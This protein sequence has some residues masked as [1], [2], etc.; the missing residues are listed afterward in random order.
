MKKYFLGLLLL[1]IT[2]LNAQVT[3]VLNDSVYLKYSN[4]IN[5]NGKTNYLG[6]DNIYSTDLIVYRDSSKKHINSIT[7]VMN[8]YIKRHIRNMPDSNAIETEVNYFDNQIERKTYNSN[9]DCV[10]IS[11][12]NYSNTQG[13]Y[14]DINNFHPNTT[15]DF[16]NDSTISSIYYPGL[17]I[18]NKYIISYN[19]MLLSY[20]EY[21]LNGN[22]RL[23]L[24]KKNEEYV[25][26]L[27]YESG[28][29][30]NFGTLRQ[31]TS[32]LQKNSLEI[33]NLIFDK[34]KL[35]NYY[36]KQG[37]IERTEHY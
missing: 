32:K 34:I 26:F 15:L 36:D 2:Q 19:D 1:A 27:F 30:Q 6:D 14:I 28:M 5:Y 11:F 9:G 35:W 22:I 31:N 16:S 21:H 33:N 4:L 12:A 13:F 17:N 20:Q 25:Y 23:S 10:F 29:L 24:N 8:G 7:T 37:N 3:M 18:L